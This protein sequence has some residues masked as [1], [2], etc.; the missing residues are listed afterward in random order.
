M[1]LVCQAVHNCRT[2]LRRAVLYQFGL[3]QICTRSLLDDKEPLTSG[4][5]FMP[6]GQLL[7]CDGANDS[8]KLFDETFEIAN[9]FPMPHNTGDVGIIDNE[10]IV[11]TLPDTMALMF[12][13]LF[14]DYKVND[15]FPIGTRANSIDVANGVIFAS[16]LTPSDESESGYLSEIRIFNMDGQLKKAF[17]IG[18][19]SNKLAVDK[20]GRRIFVLCFD[21]GVKCYTVDGDELFS[22]TGD[23][24]PSSLLF[25]VGDKIWSN[26]A[27]AGPRSTLCM[28]DEEHV[29]YCDP[30]TIKRINI[31]SQNQESSEILNMHEIIQ[32][33][34]RIGVRHH[35]LA[36]A[37]AYRSSD[38]T[39]VIG[40]NSHSKLLLYKLS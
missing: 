19:G 33:E 31:S 34:H 15:V 7:I 37:V 36:T 2:D 39:L 1:C 11:V 16:G 18:F 25:M 32:K 30:V 4:C 6:K 14:P 40:S 28:Y 5:K 13:Q 35:F 24:G 27:V 22:S 3:K 20:A 38:K 12:I 17:P 29:I 8:F 10:H 23:T 26:S 9:V 21:V